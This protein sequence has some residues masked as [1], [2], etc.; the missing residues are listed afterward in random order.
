EEF[1]I[2]QFELNLFINANNVDRARQ[3][4]FEFKELSKTTMPETKGFQIKGSK[5]IFQELQHCIH[6][7]K[8]EHNIDKI[9]NNQVINEV[10]ES[11]ESNVDQIIATEIENLKSD[12]DQ[13]N[14]MEHNTAFIELFLKTVKHDYEN[15]G[16]Q[17]QTAIEKLAERYNAAK[18]KSI[19]ALTSF[20]YNI[21]RSVD[22][23]TRVKSDAKIQTQVE[24]VKRRKKA[25][26]DK[27]NIIIMSCQHVK[28]EQ[29]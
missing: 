25:V 20:L 10:Q 3:W 28:N 7:E 27:E 21:D 18:A 4:F 24:S 17:F 6:S 13:I 9:L 29:V 23:L 19:L 16:P 2:H 1:I 8:Q 12:M 26:C 22:P 15:C 5:V 14:T 11:E